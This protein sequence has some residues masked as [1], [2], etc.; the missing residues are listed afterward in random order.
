MEEWPFYEDYSIKIV[1]I[2]D[3]NVGKTS[4]IKNFL[5]LDK[6]RPTIGLDY[7]PILFDTNKGIIKLNIIDTS[8]HE[9]FREITKNSFR[10]CEG[11]IFIYDISSKES[12][13]FI[14]ERLKFI[15][16]DNLKDCNYEFILIENK[17]DLKS[18]ITNNE[19][20]E[21]IS[22]YNLDFF[23]YGNFINKNGDPILHL[24]EKI[25][26]NKKILPDKN[27]LLKNTENLSSNHFYY[28]SSGFDIIINKNS[29]I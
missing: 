4:F 20:Y 26:K 1:L 7:F 18:E 8:G 19:K 5:S 28:R 11:I 3:Y 23:Q 29:C 9:R 10:G 16:N 25:F 12:F 17:I 2:G 22:K 6:I 15:T 24:I 14:K 13:N 27:I 21:L